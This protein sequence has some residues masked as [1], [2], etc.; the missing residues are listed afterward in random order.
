MTFKAKKLQNA[1]AK[2][3]SLSVSTEAQLS[4]DFGISSSLKCAKGSKSTHAPKIIKHCIC[5]QTSF[6]NVWTALL[7]SELNGVC[8]LKVLSSD[9]SRNHPLKHSI[10]D[11]NP[12]LLEVYNS[13]V[14]APEC[15]IRSVKADSSS[16]LFKISEST[17]SNTNLKKFGPN[18]SRI[19]ASSCSVWYSSNSSKFSIYIFGAC[20]DYQCRSSS[21]EF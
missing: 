14:Q 9:Y 4:P 5:K 11:K 2:E 8:D 10:S 15:F 17:M 7:K 19:S 21:L 12:D 18:V 13:K 6:N 16:K 1:S 3:F 20:I